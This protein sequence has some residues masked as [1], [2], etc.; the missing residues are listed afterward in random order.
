M[1]G[2][3]TPTRYLQNQDQIIIIV[4]LINHTI[5]S[6][7]YA[8]SPFLTFDFSNTVR[9]RFLG[10]AS[11]GVS[12]TLKVLPYYSALELFQVAVSSW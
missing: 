9:A 12:Q 6:L 2:C 7:P 5:A 1:V 11:N 4:Y 3:F 8:V 10:Q